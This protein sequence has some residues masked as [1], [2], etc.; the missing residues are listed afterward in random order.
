MKWYIAGPMSGKPQFNIPGF[1]DARND[2]IARGLAGGMED[3]IIPADALNAEEY[4]LAMQ[5]PDG[6]PGGH[7]KPYNHCLADDI[8]L[9]LTSN[10]EAVLLLQ[11]WHHS[12]GA[13]IEV[14]IA[15]SLGMRVYFR[16]RYNTISELSPGYILGLLN[17][18]TPH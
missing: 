11:D 4:A 13:R 2:L 17:D 1:L 5:S 6:A 15:V 8:H 18:N 9:W 3:V 7:T 10:T 14:F 16:S 12:R